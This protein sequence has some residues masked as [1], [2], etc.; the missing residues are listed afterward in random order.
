MISRSDGETFHLLLADKPRP[1][2]EERGS[3]PGGSLSLCFWYS[4]GKSRETKSAV[5]LLDG[6]NSE[7]T[8]LFRRIEEVAD[9]LAAKLAAG[10]PISTLYRLAWGELREL[11]Y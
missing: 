2:P 1:H 4:N 8:S 11:A 5:V 7:G 10:E 3:L 6:A 9:L